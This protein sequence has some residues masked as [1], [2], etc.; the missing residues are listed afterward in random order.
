MIKR[1]DIAESI[2]SPNDCVIA[3]ISVEHDHMIFNFE[4]DL[5]NR[6]SIQMIHPSAMSLIMRFHLVRYPQSDIYRLYARKLGKFH[7]GYRLMKEKTL[8]KLAGKKEKLTYLYHYVGSREMIIH[9]SG[10][11]NYVL[12][13]CADSVELEWVESMKYVL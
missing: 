6:E 2:P 11:S 13:V 8:F 1:Y 5:F 7:E 3:G 4:K 12:Y 10:K 9:L